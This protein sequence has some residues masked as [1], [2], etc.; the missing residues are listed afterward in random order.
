MKKPGA[1][2]KRMACSPMPPPELWLNACATSPKPSRIT[3]FLHDMNHP[4]FFSC[5]KNP[6]T[7]SFELGRKKNI[8]NVSLSTQFKPVCIPLGVG[9]WRLCR[10]SQKSG[11]THFFLCF[12]VFFYVKH[13]ARV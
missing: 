10:L 4:G 5:E 12:I 1:C 6:L 2:S 11:M 13:V 8:S 9:W 3:S 7:H